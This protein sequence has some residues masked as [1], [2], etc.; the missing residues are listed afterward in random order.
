MVQGQFLNLYAL[1]LLA[2]ALTGFCVSMM[3]TGSIIVAS[4]RYPE[5][6]VMIFALMAA[7][8]DFGAS[9]GPQLVGVITDAAI[10]TPA[11]ISLAERLSLAPDQL[12]M[13]LGMLVGMLFPLIAIPIYAHFWKQDKNKSK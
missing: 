2:C 6:G 7:G 9:M 11:L 12:G 5:G 8:G 1:E 10:E 4:D 13:K 3:W